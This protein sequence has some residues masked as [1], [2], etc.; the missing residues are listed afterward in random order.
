MFAL[1]KKDFESNIDRVFF[2][3]LEVPELSQDAHR[4]LDVEAYLDFKQD[5]IINELCV[6][7]SLVK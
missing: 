2:P 6:L 4:H 1:N 3:K 5:M 7:K